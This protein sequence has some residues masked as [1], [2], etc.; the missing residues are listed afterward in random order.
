[1]MKNTML[2]RAKRMELLSEV[3]HAA[4]TAFANVMA[5]SEDN[6]LLTVQR[7]IRDANIDDFIYQCMKPELMKGNFNVLYLDSRVVGEDKARIKAQKELA[8]IRRMSN[9]RKE[10]GETII[11]LLFFTY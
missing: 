8:R 5:M 6:I 11:Q 9:K 1:M 3:N 2:P 4:Y 7:I 10:A